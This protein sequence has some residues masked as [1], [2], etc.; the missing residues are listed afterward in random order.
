ME[1]WC[2]SNTTRKSQKSQ[3]TD[4][5]SAASFDAV[6]SLSP[7]YISNYILN[8][9]KNNDDEDGSIDD[10]SL[11][12][13]IRRIQG[14]KIIPTILIEEIRFVGTRKLRRKSQQSYFRDEDED[15]VDASDADNDDD[16]LANDESSSSSSV[17]AAVIGREPDV[18]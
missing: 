9:N 12:L 7:E 16:N 15:D 4:A 10:E 5:A 6:H 11:V 1:W 3:T 8:N 2:D 14:P 17:P 13:F 18:M